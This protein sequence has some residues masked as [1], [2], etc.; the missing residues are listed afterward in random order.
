LAR[1][2]TDRKPPIWREARKNSSKLNERPENVY[3]NKGSLWK[4]WGLSW[5]VIEKTGTYVFNPGMLLKTHW[6]FHSG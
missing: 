5:N 1:R 2:A 6:L 4:N 3:E